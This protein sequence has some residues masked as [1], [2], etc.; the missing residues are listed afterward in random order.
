M[1]LRKFYYPLFLNDLFGNHCC[2]KMILLSCIHYLQVELSRSIANLYL[3]ILITLHF[4][5]RRH[6]FIIFIRPCY[7]RLVVHEC[8]LLFDILDLPINLRFWF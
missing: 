5:P 2:L 4:N 1:S 3:E 7:H 6:E 8:S